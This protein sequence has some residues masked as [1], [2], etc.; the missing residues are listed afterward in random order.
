MFYHAFSDFP[1]R[2][3]N[4]N[5]ALASVAFYTV[6]NVPRATSKIVARS[7]SYFTVGVLNVICCQFV[8]VRAVCLRCVRDEGSLACLV[9]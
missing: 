3:P 7:V 8:T 9:L 1:L 6:N 2:F 4:I 5:N